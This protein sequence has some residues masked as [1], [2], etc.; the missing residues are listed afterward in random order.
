MDDWEKFNETTLPEKE[1]F[2]SNLNLDI[3]DADYMHGK[4]VC[5]DFEI[6][7]LSGY[8]N[9][10]LKSDTLVLADVFENFRK[11][12]LKIYELDPAKFLSAPGLAW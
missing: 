2:Y 4:R 7:K 5:I 1:E 6:K 10:Y 12:C 3:T 9:L 11:I 8:H